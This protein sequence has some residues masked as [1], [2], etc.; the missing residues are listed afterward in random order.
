MANILIIAGE[1]S[2][3][4]HGA[5][6]V[7]ELHQLA[8]DCVVWGIGGVRMEAAG[9]KIEYHISQMAFLGFS[10]VIKHL[11]FIRKVLHRLQSLVELNK[12]DLVILIDYPGFNLR[13]AKFAH[14]RGIK[15][16]YYISPQVW[17]WGKNRIKK[18]ARRIDHMAVIFDFE[19]Q[20]Y[21]A[22][23]VPVTFVGHPLLDTIY[24][25]P[26]REEFLRSY[27]LDSQSP[28][29][30]LLPGSREQEVQRLLP[31]MLSIAAEFKNH[32]PECQIAVSTT[33]H[34]P[35]KLYDD[36]LQSFSCTKVTD[37]YALMAY[38]TLMMVASGTATLESAII[39]TPFVMVYRV[40]PLSYW[41]GKRLIKIDHLALAN[42]VAGK[43]VVPEF[44]Q[45][46]F[47]AATVVPALLNLLRSET[48]RQKMKS[49]FAEI[50]QKIGNA[51]ASHRVAEL[52][53][54]LL[55][56]NG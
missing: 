36:I 12:P 20:L 9:V 27:G 42:V 2:G 45:D 32:C 34:I 10:E 49:E 41:L 56:K 5:N 44:I 6:L 21:E 54:A 39:G 25:A 33:D 26:T 1:T 37:T 23:H 17:A 47:C 50:R 35:I 16:L 38:A 31:E 29:L 8:P 22:Y 46:E 24:I 28:I 13:M 43:R 18:I 14:N 3:D 7:R 55:R 4:L 19:R 53:V 48:E 15:V 30:A 11:P 52:A 40:S 51:G